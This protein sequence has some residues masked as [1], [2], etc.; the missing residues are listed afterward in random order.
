MA[1]PGKL[2]ATSAF[3][4]I[5]QLLVARNFIPPVWVWE[6]FH[7]YLRGYLTNIASNAHIPIVNG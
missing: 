4:N 1:Y 6:F 2:R 5:A 7:E 3:R